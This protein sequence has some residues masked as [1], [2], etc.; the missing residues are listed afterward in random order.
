[1]SLWGSIRRVFTHPYGSCRVDGCDEPRERWE[2]FCG[3]H[4]SERFAEAAKEY[5]RAEFEREVRIHT[6]ALRRVQETRPRHC[7]HTA[8]L[9]YDRTS[10]ATCDL[11]KG[12]RGDHMDYGG[13]AWTDT[14][15][16]CK[17]GPNY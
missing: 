10:W 3:R 11:V 16:P 1:M 15:M 8:P 2:D 4:L 17:R 14:T 13:F 12:H 7:G 9:N 6:E 5:A